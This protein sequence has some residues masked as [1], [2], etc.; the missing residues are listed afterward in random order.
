MVGVSEMK[1]YGYLW[2]RMLPTG[3]EKAMELNQKGVMV[4][5]L[6]LNDTETYVQGMWMICRSMTGC[7]VWRR[8]IRRND[9]RAGKYRNGR[10][11]KGSIR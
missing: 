1:E 10:N 7:S 8:R 5:E 4:L 11:R 2:D 3:K 6:Y 9:G